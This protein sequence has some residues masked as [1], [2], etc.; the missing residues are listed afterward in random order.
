MHRLVILGICLYYLKDCPR[1]EA[2]QSKRQTQVESLIETNIPLELLNL[3]N[4]RNVAERILIKGKDLI[5]NGQKFDVT[6][7]YTPTQQQAELGHLQEFPPQFG[8]RSPQLGGPP[9]QF[10][11][12]PLHFGG[13]R[14]Q[15]GGPPPQFGG[16]HFQPEGPPPQFG[17]RPPHHGGPAPEFEGPTPEFG[18]SSPKFGGPPPK[19]EGPP[20]VFGGPPRRVKNRRPGWLIPSDFPGFKVMEGPSGPPPGQFKPHRRGYRPH[21]DH[22]GNGNEGERHGFNRKSEGHTQD[23]NSDDESQISGYIDGKF[24]VILLDSEN[25]VRR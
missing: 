18:D 1:V 10:G 4:L 5:Q 8:G 3:G 12:L 14:P 24:P 23:K 21:H 19:F 17:G 13:R 7:E 20:P 11:G 16:R 2:S 15:H 22:H 6:I 9:P 25:E